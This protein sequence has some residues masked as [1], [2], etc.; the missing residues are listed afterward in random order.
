M[1]KGIFVLLLFVPSMV[2]AQPLPEKGSDKP[3]YGKFE[4]FREKR[5]EFRKQ[6]EEMK[7]DRDK[8][9]ALIK[10]P[11]SSD[12]D[13][14]KLAD[15]IAAKIS[16]NFKMRINKLLEMRKTLPPEQFEN[17]LERFEERGKKWKEEHKRN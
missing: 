4:E 3:K 7:A 6:R 13:I 12:A 15:E 5:E 11:K 17:M 1:K 16:N 14:Q 8:L 10:D 2:F 9:K